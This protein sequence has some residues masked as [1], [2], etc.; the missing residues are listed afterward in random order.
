MQDSEKLIFRN[1]SPE[2]IPDWLAFLSNEIFAGDPPEAVSAIWE[3][4]RERSTNGIFIAADRNG[5]IAGSV[6]AEC[7]TLLFRGFPILTGIIS[8]VGVKKEFRGAGISRTLFDMC[9]EYLNSRGV[10]AAYLY[11][12]PDT[13][14]YY[15][16]LGYADCRMRQGEDFYRMLRLIRPFRVGST[17][18]G[19]TEELIDFIETPE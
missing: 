7:R 10:S 12:K 1:L 3:N 11:S 13:L 15:R 17:R 6:C 9:H 18:I 16:R 19:C 2:E 14:E 4:N 8:G 5:S